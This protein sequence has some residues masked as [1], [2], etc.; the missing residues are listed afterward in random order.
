MRRII[1]L[2]AAC[3]ALSYLYTLTHKQ[4][5]FRKKEFKKNVRFVFKVFYQL[6]NTTI[7][8]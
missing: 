3:L 4:H 1:F 2:S 6:I 7:Q 8:I 5:D